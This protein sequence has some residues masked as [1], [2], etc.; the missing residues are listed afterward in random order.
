MYGEADQA[1]PLGWKDIKEFIQS[2]G[3]GLRADSARALLCVAYE[4]LTRRGEL[5][6][7]KVRDIY[8]HPD[9]TGQAL[10]RRGKTPARSVDKVSGHSTRVGAAQDLAELD[11]D[12]AAMTSPGSLL[13]P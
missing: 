11:I 7:L 3:E 10:I 13:F 8:F 6:A 2:A 1:R 12:L 5:V 4:T 9:G